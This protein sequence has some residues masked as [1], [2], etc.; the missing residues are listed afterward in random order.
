MSATVARSVDLFGYLMETQL[1]RANR[2]AGKPVRFMRLE[3]CQSKLDL[4]PTRLADMDRHL[5]H[6]RMM[7]LLP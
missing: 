6:G 4:N 2:E 5:Q 1:N 7:R 3:G